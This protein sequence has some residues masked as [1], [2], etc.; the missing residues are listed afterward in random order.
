VVSGD[1]GAS[2]NSG[3]VGTKRTL[4]FLVLVLL[5]LLLASVAYWWYVKEVVYSPK[6][7]T[8]MGTEVE[9]RMLGKAGPFTVHEVTGEID[10]D[11]TGTRGKRPFASIQV[12]R[13]G[14]IMMSVD[15][16]RKSVTY[17]DEGGLSWTEVKDPDERGVYKNRQFMFYD[18]DGDLKTVLEDMNGDGV[19]DRL[20]DISDMSVSIRFNDAWV[21][22]S[23]T[24]K[25]HHS[26]TGEDGEEHVVVFRDGKWLV[27]DSVAPKD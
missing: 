13:D 5:M 2:N 16:I 1:S 18:E 12:R 6:K 15:S 3:L 20:F 19:M 7:T 10:R 9:T 14:K 11:S 23:M 8:Y 27:D 4:R 24:D 22:P 17:Y 26:V 25:I 21:R